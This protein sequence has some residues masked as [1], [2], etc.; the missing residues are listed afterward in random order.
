VQEVFE[1]I[2]KLVLLVALF[3]IAWGDYKTQLLEV[4]QLLGF[5][6][7]GILLCEDWVT[8]YHA[9]GGSLIGILVLFAAWC[10]K[11]SIGYGDGWLFVLT[12]V[13]L[14]FIQNLTL[15]LGSLILAGVF[16]IACLIL[17]KKR[18]SDS[19]ALGPFVLAAYV[20]FV[21]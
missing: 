16:A 9:I 17:K 4:R 12:G 6:A 14:G 18:R 3:V 1:I 11:E 21:L 20:L 5:G 8:L 13:F 10:S 2:S 19:M 15:L 7:V